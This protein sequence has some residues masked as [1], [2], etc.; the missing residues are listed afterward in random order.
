M[1]QIKLTFYRFLPYSTGVG[2]IAPNLKFLTHFK[3]L[4]FHREILDFGHLGIV[5][6]QNGRAGRSK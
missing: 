4:F 3:L 2:G 1:K 5:W 6:D